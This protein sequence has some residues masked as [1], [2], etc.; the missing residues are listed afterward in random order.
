MDGAFSFE[1]DDI[2]FELIKSDFDFELHDLIIF[3][4]FNF[5]DGDLFLC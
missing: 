5:Q 2:Y 3:R 1:I 4:S